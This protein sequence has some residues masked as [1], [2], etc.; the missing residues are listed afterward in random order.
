MAQHG[1]RNDTPGGGADGELEWSAEKPAKPALDSVSSPA[2]ALP[3]HPLLLTFTGPGQEAAYAM[4]FN[5]GQV[6]SDALFACLF[7]AESALIAGLGGTTAASL[8]RVSAVILAALV[9]V[10]AVA[11]RSGRYASCREL[12]VAAL[13]L[14]QAIS[15]KGMRA[16][17]LAAAMAPGGAG[18]LGAVY[19]L[20]SLTVAPL[21]WQLRFVVALPVLLAS[22]V[23]IFNAMS[24]LC[25]LPAVAPRAEAAAAANCSSLLLAARLGS[26][27][28]LLPALAL[29]LIESRARARWTSSLGAEGVTRRL[30]VT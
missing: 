30:S 19:S 3:R 4:R 21:V 6:S 23:A 8:P 16:D 10:A 22:A 11:G 15:R 2:P 12:L 14:A 13:L 1:L 24:P 25:G 26:L 29:Y 7:L 28:L 5:A 27:G 9:L 20:A 18:G 17:R